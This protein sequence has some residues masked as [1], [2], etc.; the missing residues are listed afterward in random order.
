MVPHF[1][2]EVEMASADSPVAGCRGARR[3]ALLVRVALRY[4]FARRVETESGFIAGAA[5]STRIADPSSHAAGFLEGQ[6][7]RAG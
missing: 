5:G 6:S 2:C 1:E 4:F 7:H 3:G